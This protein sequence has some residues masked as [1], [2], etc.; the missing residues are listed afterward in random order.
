MVRVD[1]NSRPSTDA[2]FPTSITEPSASGAAGADRGTSF[3]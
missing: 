1:S 3:K 2:D